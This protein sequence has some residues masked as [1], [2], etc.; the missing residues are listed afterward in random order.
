MRGRMAPSV[1]LLYRA[2][3]CQPDEDELPRLLLYNA[4]LSGCKYDTS[5]VTGHAVDK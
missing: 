5:I 4:H 1:K 3:M 2:Y